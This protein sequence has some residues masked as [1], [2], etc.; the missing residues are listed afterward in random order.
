MAEVQIKYGRKKGLNFSDGFNF[1]GLTYKQ[2]LET[3]GINI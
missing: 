2:K 3:F 1:C